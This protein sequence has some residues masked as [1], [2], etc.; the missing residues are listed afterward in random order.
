MPSEKYTACSFLEKRSYPSPF[1]PNTEP[2]GSSA[3]A[4][5]ATSPPARETRQPG[6]QHDPRVRAPSVSRPSDFHFLSHSA[7]KALLTSLSAYLCSFPHK[8]APG[9]NVPGPL[10]SL[11]TVS[12]CVFLMLVRTSILHRQ[13]L[14]PTACVCHC[15]L[16]CCPPGVH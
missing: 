5:T 10:S 15:F 2:R 7:F 6:A 8:G 14:H 9:N 16:P 1:L 4:W 11:G 12:I 13:P 3:A